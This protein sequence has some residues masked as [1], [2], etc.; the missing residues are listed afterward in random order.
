MFGDDMIKQEYRLKRSA[1]LNRAQEETR[2]GNWLN[3]SCPW[4]LLA[5]KPVVLA[6]LT[7]TEG[8]EKQGNMGASIWNSGCRTQ[9]MKDGDPV[10]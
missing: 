5:R 6:A 9:W 3:L 10:V 1:G 7:K 2:W 8:L 4:S